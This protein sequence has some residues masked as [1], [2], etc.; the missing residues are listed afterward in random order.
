MMYCVIIS[1][2]CIIH[3][4]LCHGDDVITIRVNSMTYSKYGHLYAA[5]SDITHL[6]FAGPQT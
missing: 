6:S 1:A 2:C 5:A 4:H 3:V